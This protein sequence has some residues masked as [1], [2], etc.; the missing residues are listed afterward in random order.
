MIKFAKHA[1]SQINEKD[2][3]AFLK[4][5]SKESFLTRKSIA[6]KEELWTNFTIVDDVTKKK[7][8]VIILPI[9]DKSLCYKENGDLLT[10]RSRQKITFLF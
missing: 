9:H 3:K 7:L 8:F 5:A 1:L 10:L 2:I 4:Q 6:D